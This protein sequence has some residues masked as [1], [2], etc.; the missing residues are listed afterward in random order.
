[1]VVRYVSMLD[2]LFVSDVPRGGDGVSAFLRVTVTALFL[3]FEA[4][5]IDFTLGNTIGSGLGSLCDTSTL[6][7]G[8]AS[9]SPSSV[10]AVPI[11]DTPRP[12]NLMELGLTAVVLAS[13]ETVPHS[14]DVFVEFFAVSRMH[15]Y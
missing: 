1:M 6:M 13:S 5:T 2:F 14:T 7:G 9:W 15:A 10:S 3:M 8:A 4:S 11:S 12:S